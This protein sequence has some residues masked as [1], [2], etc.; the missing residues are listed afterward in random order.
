MQLSGQ[1][2]CVK[3]GAFADLLVV[4]GDPLEDISLLAADGQNLSLIVRG[5]EIVKN[6][7]S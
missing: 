2:G 7:L 6:R 3:P 1:I 5:G 4:D